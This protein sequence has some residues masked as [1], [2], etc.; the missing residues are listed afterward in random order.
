MGKFE[1]TGKDF[2]KSYT[3]FLTNCHVRENVTHLTNINVLP[4][5]FF[6]KQSERGRF[7]MEKRLW[8]KTKLFPYFVIEIGASIPSESDKYSNFSTNCQYLD[9]FCGNIVRDIKEIKVNS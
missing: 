8:N 7:K 1:S 5:L 3:T 4:N 9:K 2:M 6:L